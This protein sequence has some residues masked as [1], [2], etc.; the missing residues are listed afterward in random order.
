MRLN[1]NYFEGCC[2]SLSI[3]ETLVQ[4]RMSH[5]HH[6]RSNSAREREEQFVGPYKLEKT[7]GKGQ[8]GKPLLYFIGF[9]MQKVSLWK[10]EQKLEKIRIRFIP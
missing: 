7:L 3:F 1:C 6:H 2:R 4:F 8:T 5:H 10:F 9:I